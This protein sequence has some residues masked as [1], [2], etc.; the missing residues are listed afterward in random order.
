M[1]DG[2]TVQEIDPK[3]KAAA[4]IAQLWAYL[5]QQINAPTRKEGAA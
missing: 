5:N 3:G 4:E 1:T 2:R